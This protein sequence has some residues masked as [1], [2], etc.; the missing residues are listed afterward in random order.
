[1]PI[2]SLDDVRLFRQVAASGGIS[3]AARVLGD[4]K[5]RVSQRLAVLEGQLG[6]RLAV[7]DTRSFSL[8]EEGERFLEQSAGLLEAAERAE[9]S[10]VPARALEG[11]VKVALRSALAGVG[12]G[13]ELARL[14]HASPGLR[15]QVEVVDEN[16][17]LLEGAFDLAI[18]VG[19]LRASSLVATRLE[20]SNWVLAATP[21]YLDAHGRPRTPAGLAGHRCILTLTQPRETHWALAGPRGERRRVPVSGPFECNDAHFQG[22]ALGAGLG[23][24]LRTLAEVERGAAE[25]RLERVLPGWRHQPV[26]VWIVAPPG[27]T[28]VPRVAAVAGLLRRVIE[29]SNRLR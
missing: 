17:P 19:S 18:H 2:G 5:R 3:A 29:G 11:R 22:E 9:R 7:R 21:G 16:R 1:M 12:L 24:G 15:L 28:R 23:I 26:Q 8:T 27:R 10:L 13:A 4:S 25:G 14:V 6:A 20:L